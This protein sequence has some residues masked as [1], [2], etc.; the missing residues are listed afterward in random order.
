[1]RRGMG[2]SLLG[3]RI[4]VDYPKKHRGIISVSFLVDFRFDSPLLESRGP[5]PEP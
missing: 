1:M 4:M 5:N 2:G 3:E